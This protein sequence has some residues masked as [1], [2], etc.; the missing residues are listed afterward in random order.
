MERCKP[1]F[2]VGRLGAEFIH[3]LRPFVLA[4]EPTEFHRVRNILGRHLTLKR[5][6]DV[7]AALKYLFS[8]RRITDSIQVTVD[9][10]QVNSEDVVTKCAQCFEYHRDDEK[11]DAITA[12]CAFRN[13]VR[14]PVLRDSS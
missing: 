11:R 13:V 4:N 2:Q 12:L 8:G 7:L 5:F 1:R 14:G 3:Q 6:R 9:D 10:T